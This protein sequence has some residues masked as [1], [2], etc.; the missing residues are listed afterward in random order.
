ML[1]PAAFLAERVDAYDAELIDRNFAA[2]RLVPVREHTVEEPG[3]VP[4]V[5]RVGGVLEGGDP[6]IGGDR[7]TV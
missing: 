7:L 2:D 5:L 3:E 1:E 6:V 4:G